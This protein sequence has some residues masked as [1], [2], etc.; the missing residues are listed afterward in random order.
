MTRPQQNIEK[1]GHH[2]Q[3]EAHLNNEKDGRHLQS[4]AHLNSG[5]QNIIEKA[6]EIFRGEIV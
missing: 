3:G 6:I 5:E 2:L 1:D 4:G